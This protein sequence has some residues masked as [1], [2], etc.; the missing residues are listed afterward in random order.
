MILVEEGM[1]DTNPKDFLGAS[2]LPMHLVPD[3][4]IALACLAHLDGALKYG[5]WNWRASGVRASIYRAALQRHL[6]AWWNGED[7]DPDSELPHLAMAMACLN[8]L[9]DATVC[10][11]LTDDRPPRAPIRDWFTK[12]TAHV[13]RLKAK[14]A[15]K[16]PHHYTL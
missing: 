13:S 2:K 11:K 7:I 3:T 9:V 15:D 10:E 5:A 16:N 14:H 4:A 6:A 8:I 12:L 1:K